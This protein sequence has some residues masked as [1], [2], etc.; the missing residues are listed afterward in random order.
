MEFQELNL[1]SSFNFECGPHLPCFTECCK[2]LKLVLT[3]YDCIKLKGYL[4]L[5]SDEFLDAYCDLRYE[6]GIFP[7][8]YLR[9]KEDGTCPFLSPSGCK[10]YEA[11]PAACRL[12]PVGRG[13][14]FVREEKELFFLVKE[15]HC[16]GHQVQ[17]EWSISEWLNHEGVTEY[18]KANAPWVQVV[19][20][21]NKIDKQGL[22]KKLKM[23]L[24]ASYNID[25][26]REFVFGTKF[27]QIFPFEEAQKEV[28][29]RDDT[30]LLRLGMEF[31]KL[32]FLGESE[33]KPSNIK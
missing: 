27:F 9:M 5:S 31:L 23:F 17:R 8:Y 14:T 19:T 18:D 6:E 11:R 22:E 24:M 7:L 12:Y 10:V 13:S 3:P 28:Y 20:S 30:A 21:G 32:S 33:L 2:R 29:K 15:K 1:S 4:N 16:L 25:K 26:F